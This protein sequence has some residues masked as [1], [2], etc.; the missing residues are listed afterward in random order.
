MMESEY[1]EFRDE[2]TICDGGYC[3]EI[4]YRQSEIFG[5]VICDEEIDF[6]M[7]GTYIRTH[8]TW[9]FLGLISFNAIIGYLA[10]RTYYWVEFPDKFISIFSMAY[11]LYVITNMVIYRCTR[12]IEVPYKTIATS[13]GNPRTFIHAFIFGFVFVINIP[14]IIIAFIQYLIICIVVFTV[15]SPVYVPYMMYRKCA[16]N[17]NANTFDL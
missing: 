17:H 4:E 5:S 3:C 16:A 12:E 6:N 9:F 11:G 7:K 1:S 8:P 14:F 10:Y 15:I 13:C 2:R